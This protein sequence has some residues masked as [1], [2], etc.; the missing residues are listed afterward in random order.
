MEEKLFK[1]MILDFVLE[2]HALS[3]SLVTSN[4]AIS[5]SNETQTE[6]LSEVSRYLVKH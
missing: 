1:R 3:I 4:R 2:R 6:N 5:W